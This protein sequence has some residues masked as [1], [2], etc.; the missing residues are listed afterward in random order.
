MNNDDILQPEGGWAH[1]ATQRLVPPPPEQRGMGFRAAFRLASLLSGRQEMPGLF[2]LLHMHARAFWPWLWFASRLTASGRLGAAEREKVILRT[3]W[4]CRSRYEWGHHVSIGLAVG[5]SDRD[6][7]SV[8]QG[9]ASS[10][11]PREQALLQACDELVEHKY[12]TESVWNALTQYYDAPTLL[13]I[14]LLVGHY[15][16]LAGVLNSAGIPLDARQEGALRAFSA[17]IQ[18]ERV[19]G[20]AGLHASEGSPP[21]SASDGR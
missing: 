20:S 17:R 10:S 3:A 18:A 21:Q 7:V 12:V 4:N 15:A 1:A 6:I 8:A 19:V 16:M 14:G 9:P 13:E 2:P 11:D 5:L